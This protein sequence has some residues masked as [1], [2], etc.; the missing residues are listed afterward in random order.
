MKNLSTRLEDILYSDDD[1][2]ILHPNVKKGILIFTYYSHPDCI[3]GLKTGSQLQNERIYFD[4]SI[5]HPYIFFR[6]PFFSNS[7]DYTTIDTEIESSY[8]KILITSPSKIWIRIDPDRTYVYSSEIRA[9]Y[10]SLFYY[11]SQE[12]LTDM[13]REVKRSRKLMT[14]YLEII[15]ENS[16]VTIEP[17][18]KQ[19]YNLVSSRLQLFP[20]TYNLSYPWNLY[21]INKQSEVIVRINHLTPNYFVNKN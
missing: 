10:K 18:K 14:N 15:D 16:K 20:N 2:C 12:Y 9:E 19:L 4:R 17:D 11:N 21:N 6:A 5:I 13:E 3:N 1:V 7:I 8:G